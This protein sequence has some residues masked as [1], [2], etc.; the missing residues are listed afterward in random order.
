MTIEEKI[1]HLQ[2]AAMEEARAEGNAIM[3]QHE[4]ALLGVFEQHRA[5]ILRQSETRVKAERVGAQ[6]QLNMAMSK[7]QL[8]LKRELSKTQKELKKKLFE[9]V[10]EVVQEYMKTD[11]YP[12]LLIAYIEKAA[13]FADGA[14]MTIYINPTDEDKKE[15]LEEHTGMMLTVSKE[16][17][18]GG[19][20]A[21]I[22]EKNVLID[23][24]FKG[25][26]ESEYRKFV[27]K[28]GVQVG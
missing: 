23:H 4:D 15:F 20:R 13:K 22:H 17:F 12:R 14:S 3:K 2:A 21:V 19:V 27:F 28:G 25:A 7:A 6:Q 18:I 11:E 9:E 26:I 5:E 1:S 24:A 10:E 16:D 8:E